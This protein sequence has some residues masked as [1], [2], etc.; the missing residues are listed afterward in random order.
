MK[1]SGPDSE[2][3]LGQGGG[4]QVQSKGSKPAKNTRPPTVP[5]T[6]GQ[7]RLVERF[8]PRVK[9]WW[10]NRYGAWPD[11]DDILGEIYLTLCKLAK[12]FV[13]SSTAPDEIVPGLPPMPG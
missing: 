7:R 3:R 8:L 4:Q 9:V 11:G 13:S 12:R 5:L 2:P 10:R 1:S 6:A